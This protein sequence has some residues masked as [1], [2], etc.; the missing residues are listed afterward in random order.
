MHTSTA[1]EVPNPTIPTLIYLGPLAIAEGLKTVLPHIPESILVDIALRVVATH[2][3][4]TRNIAINTNRGHRNSGSAHVEVVTNFGL[5]AT[6]EALTS[7]AQIYASLL[8]REANKLHKL[9]VLLHVKMQ[10]VIPLGTSCRED[11]EDSPMAY[12]LAN[13]KLLPLV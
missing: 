12:A 4:T 5:V 10:R 8:S 7:I 2:T 3:R 1:T 11:G 9:A 13:E 6:E